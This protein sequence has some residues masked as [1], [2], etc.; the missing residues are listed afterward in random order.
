M[1]TRDDRIETGDPEEGG[2]G[3]EGYSEATRLP[4]LSRLR[5]MDVRTG[6]GE[7]V[8]TVKD[9]YLD[10]DAR[11]SRYLAVK[12]GWF[13]GTHVV[14]V[15]DVDFVDDGDP[16]V[17]VPYPAGQM[18]DAPAFGDDDELTPER[19]R[20]IYDHYQRVGYW[21]ESRDIVRARQTEPAPTPQ[22][23]EAEVAD[24]IRR[25]GDP[26]RVRVKRWGA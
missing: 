2:I 17:V 11:H 13:S 23:A 18:K 7:K 16:H 10:A 8:G 9:V 5:G 24:E 22:I 12:T 3:P 6:D 20:E 21:D 15:D 25:G 26:Q 19:E 14:P 4:S 1:S